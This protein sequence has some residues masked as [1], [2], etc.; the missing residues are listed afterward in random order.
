M[1]LP[2]A[3]LAV[4]VLLAVAPVAG[5]PL[6][7]LVGE[8]NLAPLRGAAPPPLALERLGDGRTVSLAHFKG[9]PVLVYFCATW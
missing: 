2:A 9:R 6:D 3:A 8:L 7:D 4:A 5:A 1:R